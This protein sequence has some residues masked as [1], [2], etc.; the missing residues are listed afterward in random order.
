VVAGSRG[1][2]LMIRGPALL[3]LKPNHVDV[4]VVAVVHDWGHIAGLSA[5]QSVSLI[6]A[7]TLTLFKEDSVVVYAQ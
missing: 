1:T 5:V 6:Q 7:H 2:K 3:V 4:K